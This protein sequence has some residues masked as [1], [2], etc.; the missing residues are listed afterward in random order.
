MA[1]QGQGLGPLPRTFHRA[2]SPGHPSL[3]T[4][5]DGTAFLVPPALLAGFLQQCQ[6]SPAL[7]ARVRG[8]LVAPAPAPDYSQAAAAPLAPFALYPNQS[9]A[10]NPTGA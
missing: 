6:D 9:Y 8:V 3:P 1:C 2:S 10:W 7:A 4:L 5:A